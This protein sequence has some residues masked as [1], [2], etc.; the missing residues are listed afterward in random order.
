M[1]SNSPVQASSAVH[2]DPAAP[3]LHVHT[4]RKIVKTENVN[5]IQALYQFAHQICIYT[6][7]QNLSI[8]CDALFRVSF[9]PQWRLETSYAVDAER[10]RF[11]C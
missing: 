3:L 1:L 5:G 6:H 9:G 10:M 8:C 4:V 7:T 2:P 11:Q